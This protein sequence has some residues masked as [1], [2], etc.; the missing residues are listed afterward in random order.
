MTTGVPLAEG[1]TIAVTAAGELDSAGCT[2]QRGRSEGNGAEGNVATGNTTAGEPC[3]GRT[4]IIIV[5]THLLS[6]VRKGTTMYQGL[7][8]MLPHIGIVL[9][10]AD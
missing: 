5:I 4:Y 1:G 6:W 7:M 8:A 2:C 9:Y 3:H 10:V